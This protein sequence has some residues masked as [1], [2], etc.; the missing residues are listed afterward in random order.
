MPPPGAAATLT[1]PACSS[2]DLAHDREP[3]AATRSRARA[4]RRGRSGRTRAAGPP[5]RFPAR[6]RGPRARRRAAGPRS[7]RSSPANLTALSS[8]LLTARSSLDGTPLTSVAFE[9]DLEANVRSVAARPLDRLGHEDVEAHLLARVDVLVLA[10][11]FDQVVDQRRELL[12]LL[13][14]VARSGGGAPPPACSAARSR[15]SMFVRTLVTGVRSSCEASATRRR[16]MRADSSSLCTVSSSAVEHRV[17]AGG[18]AAQLVAAPLV[19]A[20]AEITR[21]GHVL[22]RRRQPAH[23]GQRGSRDEP[24]EQRR[25]RDAAE[26][27][28][29]EDQPQLDRASS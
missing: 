19:D 26:R 27:Q 28:D 10:R 21:L 14:D 6:G 16:C 15:I 2:R 12:E 1:L 11:Q 17:E 7:A 9:V 29:H 4:R 24:A 8:R 22:H 13:D 25:E 18:Q 3:E 23:R 20:L 5:R